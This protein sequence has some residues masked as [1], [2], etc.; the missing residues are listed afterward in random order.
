MECFTC[1]GTG[2]YIYRYIWTNENTGI[3]VWVLISELKSKIGQK[4][5]ISQVLHGF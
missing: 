1:Y 4:R 3:W 5:T 2:F